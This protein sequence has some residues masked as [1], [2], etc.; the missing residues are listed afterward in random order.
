MNDREPGL[1]GALVDSIR[2]GAPV[3]TSGPYAG[4]LGMAAVVA[5]ARAA[6][7]AA[8]RASPGARLN[9]RALGAATGDAHRRAP[10]LAL[11]VAGGVVA[12]VAAATV[13]PIPA[14]IA[15][16]LGGLVHVFVEEHPPAVTTAEDPGAPVRPGTETTVA[17]FESAHGVDVAV[18][19]ELPNGFREIRVLVGVE[20]PSVKQTIEIQFGPDASTTGLRLVV[21]VPNGPIDLAGE[22]RAVNGYGVTGVIDT[23]GDRAGTRILTWTDGRLLYQLFG[24]FTEE[25]LLR[26][27]GSA[28]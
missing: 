9:E 18:P 3:P 25:E 22:G 1:F 2:D 12:L 7:S 16:A 19:M 27:A 21:S 15:D 6:P 13:T 17:V 10:R 23:L 28:K 14:G 20:L 11:A 4:E 26:I 8:F 5:G 24:A